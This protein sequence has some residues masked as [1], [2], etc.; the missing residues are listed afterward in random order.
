MKSAEQRAKKR[1]RER[2]RLHR[3]HLEAIERRREARVTVWFP[4]PEDLNRP[5]SIDDE[6]LELQRE[7]LKEIE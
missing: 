2:E 3:R 6:V 7:L 4:K 5:A 1:R